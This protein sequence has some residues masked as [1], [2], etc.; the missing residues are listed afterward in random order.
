MQNNAVFEIPFG[1]VSTA[2]TDIFA[3]KNVLS[4]AKCLETFSTHDLN[5]IAFKGSIHNGVHLQAGTT[6]ATAT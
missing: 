5:I 3:D 1:I 6:L 2:F 4:G